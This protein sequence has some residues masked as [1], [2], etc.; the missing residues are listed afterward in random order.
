TE[1]VS[2]KRRHGAK[3]AAVTHQHHKRSGR[4]Q[5]GSRNVRKK[6]EQQNLTNKDYQESSTPGDRIRN[7]CPKHSPDRVTNTRQSDHTRRNHRRYSGQF[8]KSGASREMIEMPA[9]VFR[10]KSSQSAHH[11][12]VLSASLSVKSWPARSEVWLAVAVQPSGFQP[13]GGF[14]IN[15]PVTTVTIRYA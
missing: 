11:C 3:P 13:S 15:N 14:R 6:P 2:G 4:H 8:V 7:P 12:H 5:R 1:V 9:Q 10:N